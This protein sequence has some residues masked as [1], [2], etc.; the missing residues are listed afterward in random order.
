MGL[1]IIPITK[2]AN[3]MTVADLFFTVHLHA[4]MRNEKRLAVVGS[5]A[6]EWLMR[7]MDL[8]GV[9][10]DNHAEILL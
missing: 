2:L 5:L 10:G 1:Q 9:F 3:E 8:I 4:I 6:V 7:S